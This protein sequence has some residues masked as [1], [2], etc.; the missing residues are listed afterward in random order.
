MLESIGKLPRLKKVIDQA[1]S[2]TI[3]IYG[4][5]KT[6]SLMRSFTKK[7]DIIWPWVTSLHQTSLQ[8]SLIEKKSSLRSC[9]QVI[10][11]RIVTI[12]DKQREIS[13]L[14]NDEH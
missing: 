7:R 3:F 6:L 2:F 5:H 10:C 1:K 11:G 8:Q 4:H 14:Y 13:L 9:L 12:K